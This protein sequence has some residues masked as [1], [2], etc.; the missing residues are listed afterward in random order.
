MKVIS[1]INIQKG[2]MT[3][4]FLYTNDLCLT[5]TWKIRLN[6]FIHQN[7]NFFYV[8]LLQVF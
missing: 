1:E 7:L 6:T 4:K 5:K 2:N 8:Y 3:F